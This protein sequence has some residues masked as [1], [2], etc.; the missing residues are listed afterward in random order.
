MKMSQ[1]GLVVNPRTLPDRAELEALRP[2]WVRSIVYS[3]GDIGLLLSVLPA[4]CRLCVMTNNECAEVR[5]DWSG[6]QDALRMIVDN[7]AGRVH[8]VECGNELDAYWARN[9]ADVPPEFGARLVREAAPILKPAG[10][11]TLLASVAGPRWQEWLAAAA[12]LVRTD[13]LDGVA[14]HPYGQRPDGFK[15]PGWGFGDLRVAVARAFELAGAPVYLTE[16]GVKI[17]DAGGEDGQAAYL[18]K[19]AATIAALG[20]R[21]VPMAC[22]FAWHDA[23]GTAGEQGEDAFGLRAADGRRRPAWDAF[24]AAGGVVEPPAPPVEPPAPPE[25]PVVPEP[26]LSG[27]EAS[28]LDL[29]QAHIPGLVWNPD[30]AFAKHWRDHFGEMGSPVGPERPA[31]DGSVFQSFALG[32]FKWSGGDSVEKVA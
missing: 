26:V 25:P 21:I 7:Y 31:D 24:V 23:I 32:R 12:A 18:T 15:A 27:D 2:A 19:G 6:W 5:S 10:I 8:A 28:L 20:D 11:K 3:V 1:L 14:L 4:G 29:W 13:Q 9:P 30:A 22:Y 17:R 16:W